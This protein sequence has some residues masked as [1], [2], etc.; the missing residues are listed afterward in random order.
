MKIHEYTSG[1]CTSWNTISTMYG[2]CCTFNFHSDDVSKS[3][4]SNNWGKRSGVSI[5]FDGQVASRSGF[6]MFIHHPTEYITKATPIFSLIPGHEHFIRIYPRFNKPSKHFLSLPYE[7][8]RC[9]LPQDKDL[10]WFRQS[11]CRLLELAKAIHHECR[12][13]PYFMPILDDSYRTMKNCTIHDFDCF[14]Y[15][16]GNKFKE[17]LFY[18]HLSNCFVLC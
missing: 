11:R 10:T 16:S 18:L 7:S 13:Q 1:N 12:C 2:R 9:L 15:D 17:F 14:K 4:F 8:R 3:L 5:I 6:N